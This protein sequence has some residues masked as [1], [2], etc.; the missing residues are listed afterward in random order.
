LECALERVQD[1][2]QGALALLDENAEIFRQARETVASIALLRRQLAKSQ[3]GVTI[4]FVAGG[5]SFGVGVPLI[6][7][8]IRTENSTMTWAG[9]GTIVGIGAVWALGHYVFKWW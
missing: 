3:R 1:A 2:E 8:G 9:A 7:E 6:A 5:V 4:G